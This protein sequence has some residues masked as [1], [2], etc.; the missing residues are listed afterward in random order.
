MLDQ[1][2]RTV[3][4]ADGCPPKRLWRS[5]TLRSAAGSPQP[6]RRPRSRML[7]QALVAMLHGPHGPEIAT[8]RLSPRSGKLRRR[9]GD[10]A[11]MR[12]FKI[13]TTPGSPAARRYHSWEVAISHGQRRAGPPRP[14]GPPR[15]GVPP[16]P[17]RPGPHP[18][19]GCHPSGW[20]TANARSSSRR[21][22]ACPTARL[23]V[24]G[25]RRSTVTVQVGGS[26]GLRRLRGSRVVR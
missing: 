23:Q 20:P 11:A 6:G 25:I 3:R 10:L 18:R 5:C 2:A 24:A 13:T 15:S 8:T 16:S 4:R 9:C 21:R 7:A 26:M 22:R 1:F 19:P 12:Q 14:R 17:T